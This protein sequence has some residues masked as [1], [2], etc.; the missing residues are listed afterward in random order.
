MNLRLNANAIV[1]NE[2]G[3]I[4]LVK[5]KKG[6][7]AGGLCIPGGGVEPGE[8]GADT[9]R[10]E[11]LEETGI[12]LSGDVTPIGFCELLHAG[13]RDHRVVLLLHSVSAGT[14]QETEEGVARWMSYEEAE[15]GLI[16]F[17]KESIRMWREGRRYFR[18]VGEETG[19]TRGWRSD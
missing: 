16:P 1:T 2:E 9:A 4:L 6:P 8:F 15:G 3:T 18:L 19:V 11:V 5:L 14:P 7:F 10:R 17:A 12:K 13:V